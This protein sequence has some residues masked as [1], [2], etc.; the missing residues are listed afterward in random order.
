MNG[1]RAYRRDG[2]R[3]TDKLTEYMEIRIADPQFVQKTRRIV[4]ELRNF[5]LRWNGRAN[6]DAETFELFETQ[7]RLAELQLEHH[8]LRSL[9][10]V[11]DAWKMCIV[12]DDLVENMTDCF[13]SLDSAS[14][15]ERA[16]ILSN[17][18]DLTEEDYS[19]EVGLLPMERMHKEAND[20]FAAELRDIREDWGDRL[21]ATQE[22]RLKTRDTAKLDVW[23]DEAKA[24]MAKLEALLGER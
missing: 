19:E 7:G 4:K 10:D 12:W 1:P 5:L 9:R 8:W 11:L 24:G 16:Q 15:E 21:D 6:C 3:L 18:R 13:E 22:E 20:D 14:P 17:Y 23:I 2:E